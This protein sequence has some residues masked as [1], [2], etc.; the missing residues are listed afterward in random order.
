LA[1]GTLVH[2]VTVRRPASLAADLNAGAQIKTGT[3]NCPLDMGTRELMIFDGKA[4]RTFLQQDVGGCWFAISSRSSS[5]WALSP[6]AQ[7]AVLAIDPRAF[8]VVW[9]GLRIQ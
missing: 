5:T 4:G 3:Y 1:Y 2:S 6:A 9:S 8:K 7:R